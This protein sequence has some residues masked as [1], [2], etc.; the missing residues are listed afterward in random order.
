MKK[1]ENPYSGLVQ[2]TEGTVK[3]GLLCPTA[4]IFA[5]RV[6][7]LQTGALHT[8]LALYIKHLADLC[9]TNN[10]TLNDAEKLTSYILRLTT[11]SPDPETPDG[12]DGHG[13]GPMDT[14][15]ESTEDG[16]AALGKTKTTKG[17][18]RKAA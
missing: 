9:R 13:T 8:A 5:I 2:G 15:T 14:G 1:Y 16:H 17:K 4:D 18:T 3:I 7:N 12:H 11:C 10:W 6:V